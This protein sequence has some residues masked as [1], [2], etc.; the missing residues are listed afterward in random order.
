ML[1]L[2]VLD[3]YIARNVSMSI[4]LVL[5]VLLVLFTFFSFLEELKS[6]DLGQGNYDTLTAIEY[7]LLDIPRQ[8]YYLFPVSVLL[9]VMIGLGSLASNSELIVMRAAGVSVWRIIVSVLK[10]GL[11]FVI[12][13]VMMGEL[14]APQAERIAQTLRSEAV[15]EKLTFQGKNGLW[16]RD[17]GTFFNVREILPG[18]RLGKIYIFERD[19]DYRIKR[20][21]RAESAVYRQG[22]WVL[23]Q[24][25]RSDIGTGSVDSR[26]DDEFFWNTRLSPDLLNV[27][28]AEARIL[29][30]PELYQYVT[31]LEESGLDASVYAQ[32]FWN[33]LATPLVTAAMVFLAIPFVFG[34]L[35]SVNIGYRILVGTLLGIGF[36]ILNQMFSYMGLVFGMNPAVSALLPVAAAMLVAFLMMRRVY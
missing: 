23:Q 4:L 14:V 12:L 22:Q 13:T 16:A 8:A 9:G 31:Y 34:P 21:L 17:S 28:T 25:V 7:V 5:T 11:V 24:V 10:V 1:S 6:P 32:T 15:S 3:R 29:T 36:D 35:R 19:A 33:K 30:L 20:L 18:E 26:Y 27:V 2:P